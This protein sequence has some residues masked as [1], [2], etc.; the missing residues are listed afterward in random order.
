MWI[1]LSR[2]IATVAH[3]AAVEHIYR[4]VAFS[5][6]VSD[7]VLYPRWVQSLHWGLG[8]PLFTFQP[9]LPY[10]GMDLLYR[11]GISHPIGWRFL[12]ALGFLAGF[13][14]MYLVVL[15][16]TG[17]RWP[18]IVAAIAF[19]YAPYV[20]RNGLERGSN[21]AYS[22][23]LYPLVLW[24][25]VRVARQRT[26]GRFLF[27]TLIWAAC[28]A[29][30]VLGPLMLAPFAGVL[31]IFLVWRYRT[32]APVATLLI[33]GLLTAAIWLPMGP[34]QNWVHV[35][36]DFTQPE[37]IPAQNPIPLDRLLALPAVYDTMRDN[38]GVGDRIGLVQ[39][40]LLLAGVVAA[41]YAWKRSRNLAWMLIAATVAGLL[42]LWLFTGASDWVWSEA[43]PVMGRLLY[44]T[45]LMGVQALAAA[46]A[47]GLAVAVIGPR[48]Q[49]RLSVVLGSLLLMVALPSLYVELQHHYTTFNLPVDLPQVRA[50]EIRTSGKALTAFGEFTPRWRTAPF[51]QA[52]LRDLG[53]DFDPGA[54][55]LA[56]PPATVRL[57]ASEVRTGAWDLIVSATEPTTLTLHLLYYPRWSAFLNSP[58]DA[59]ALSPE[60]GTGY[61]QVRVPAGI[62]RI[63]LRYGSTTAERAGLVLSAA[64]FV[65]LAVLAGWM[66]RRSWG[67]T[68]MV[69][70]VIASSAAN[71][72]DVEP[73]PP[74]WFLGILA[75]LLV[76]KL[77]Y[78]DP[79]TTWLRC[80]S[81]PEQVCGA[82]E[83]VG[84]SF[85]AAPSLRGYA[86]ASSTV[87]PGSELRVDL[88]WQGE[89][90]LTTAVSSFVHVRNSKPAG[91]MNP[92]TG[93]EIWA[94]NEHVAPGGL[95][96]TEFLAGKLYKDEFRVPLP[97]DVPPGEY[98]LEV[99][100]YDP[101]SGEQLDPLPETVKPP[102]KIL[103]R[104]ILLPSVQV[105]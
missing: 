102:L 57:L 79:G 49:P 72:T 52:L 4:G 92:R 25:L 48:W 6:A 100:W 39:S 26:A 91:L 8:S 11:L 29:S 16:V 3:D 15:E 62:N 86:V 53:A 76:V 71:G 38:N 45:R 95:L 88:Y 87:R 58:G 1:G 20:L 75:A 17:R 23:F 104:S 10:Y 46:A 19:T 55:P 21:E 89:P 67:K 37:A 103:W 105:R 63:G 7:G 78:I 13:A 31:A 44:R 18:A 54:R 101:Q 94:Q 77:A 2:D 90:G 5:G 32:L 73:A 30:H 42:L 65:G 35:E 41:V 64:T 82:Q 60:T 51:D 74:V 43:A 96:A 81:T 83:T 85:P 14:G 66:L 98:F 50:A 33:G 93:N 80:V 84:V 99:G 27:A 68:E 40:V 56:N 69:V 36:R 9:P 24:S 28:I 97:S 34:E 47:G 12:I 61:A 59:I 70:P 22:V